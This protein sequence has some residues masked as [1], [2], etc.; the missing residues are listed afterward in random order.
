MLKESFLS[1]PGVPGVRSMGPAVWNWSYF[2]Q[3]AQTFDLDF[4]WIFRLT[5][6]LMF[7]TPGGVV[8]VISCRLAPVF[9]VPESCFS[10][11][12]SFTKDDGI[13]MS[14]AIEKLSKSERSLLGLN[15]VKE[16]L[17][18]LTE[19]YFPRWPPRAPPPWLTP[20]PRVAPPG[21]TM[22]YSPL[23]SHTDLPKRRIRLNL[24][25]FVNLKDFPSLKNK[26]CVLVKNISGSIVEIFCAKLNII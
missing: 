21:S 3:S 13:N 25:V 8:A 10:C 15:H 4:S 18:I 26:I 20:S 6:R 14:L 2:L 22:T 7:W 12:K 16:W 23:Q 17:L 11:I 24:K 5:T 1:D 19:R 9:S